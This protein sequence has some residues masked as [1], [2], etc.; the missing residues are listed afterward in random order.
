[1][2][3]TFVA[4]ATSS[5]IDSYPSTLAD[6]LIGGVLVAGGPILLARV[7]RNRAQLNATLRD[8]AERLR[9]ERVQQAEQA[10]LDERTRIAG[11]LHDVVAHA[12]S[13]MVVQAGGARRLAEKDPARARDAFAAVETTGREALTDIRRLL[14]VLRREDE[15][16]ALAPQPSLRHLGAL[17]R[18]SQAAGLPVTLTVDGDERPLPP[19]VDLTAYRLVQAA[20]GGALE[21]GAAGRAEVAVRYRPD[22]LEVEV[23]DDGAVDGRPPAGRRARAGQPLR[24]PAARGPATLRRPPGPRPAA[25]RGR[26]VSRLWRSL[27]AARGRSAATGCSRRRCSSPPRSRSPWSAPAR[28]R[29]DSS[30]SRP[31]ATA[32][33]WRGGGCTRWR[34]CWSWRRR[35]WSRAHCSPTRP[36]TSSRSWP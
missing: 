1:M 19:G 25:G 7:L 36:G 8:K 16:I 10:A 17:V 21:P 12:M 33:R 2:A 24:R 20:L 26:I 13:A 6:L 28:R 35:S 5:A 32:S 22:G 31:P 18:R 30:R 3:F 27:R 11:E 15:E 23:L 4:Q 9:R 14:G 29:R 34:S